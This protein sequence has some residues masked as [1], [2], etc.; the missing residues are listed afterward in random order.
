MSE[1]KQAFLPGL[2]PARETRRSERREEWLNDPEWGAW[3][4]DMPRA[5]VGDDGAKTV[6]GWKEVLL[7]GKWHMSTNYAYTDY[8]GKVKTMATQGLLKQV[9]DWL[10]RHPNFNEEKRAKFKR[11]LFARLRDP[12]VHELLP[13]LTEPE[14]EMFLA[15]RG[16]VRGGGP[17]ADDGGALEQ[18]TNFRILW[19]REAQLLHWF[20]KSQ[21]LPETE[22]E[23]REREER[24][25]R[26]RQKQR[27]K[28]KKK[29]RHDGEPDKP[30]AP[31]EAVRE[32]SNQHGRGTYLPYLQEDER[33]ARIDATIFR[34]LMRGPFMRRVHGGGG[35]ADMFARDTMALGVLRRMLQ[36]RNAEPARRRAEFCRNADLPTKLYNPG[37]VGVTARRTRARKS[38]VTNRDIRLR[39]STPRANQGPGRAPFTT[40]GSARMDRRA[41]ATHTTSLRR[42]S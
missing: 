6:V 33:F 4:S 23:K 14:C 19:S 34:A 22:E 9:Y 26:Q 15:L 41:A 42:R 5:M 1:A 18:P 25:E 11:S 40:R 28:K 29:K 30:P 31:Q 27:K 13:R 21:P 37:Q 35:G 8:A 24:G 12:E 17:S 39:K 32:Y 16:I 7:R 38:V 2:W 3:V 10:N 20:L 36:P